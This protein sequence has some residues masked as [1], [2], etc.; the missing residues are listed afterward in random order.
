[1]SEY[2]KTLEIAQQLYQAYFG[3]MKEAFAVAVEIR[4]NEIYAEAVKCLKEITE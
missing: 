2:E 4:R 3:S 1:M